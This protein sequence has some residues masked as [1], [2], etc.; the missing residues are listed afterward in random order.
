MSLIFRKSD[1]SLRFAAPSDLSF[2]A[3]SE[4]QIEGLASTFGGAPDLH[5]DV[6]APGAFAKSLEGHR[7]RSTFPA[8]LWAHRLEEP[9]GRWTEIKETRDG[10]AVA[11]RVNL[12]T[13]RGK[14]A[15]ESIRAGD[16]SGFSIG[17][18]VPSGGAEYL[19]DGVTLLK[20]IEL[21]EVSIV[22][23]PANPLARITHAKAIGSKLELVGILRN[24][25]LS[26]TAAARVAAGGW[27]ALADTTDHQHASALAAQIDAAMAALQKV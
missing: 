17:F 11:G 2:K 21:H 16:V 23:V 27:P 5:H 20:A 9:I 8:M 13:S 19:A 6:I 4:G 10:L 12:N 26:K 24:A 18:Q 14:D 25:G 7:L 22:A 1:V 3:S 15:W